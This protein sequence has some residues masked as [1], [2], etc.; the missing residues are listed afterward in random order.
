MVVLY[1]FVFS[2]PVT[3]TPKPFTLLVS[4]EDG[5][6]GMPSWYSVISCQEYT[7]SLT[8]SLSLHPVSPDDYGSVIGQLIQFNTGDTNQTHTIIIN[9]DDICED[10]ANEFFLSNI[11]LDSGA[12]PIEVIRPQAT[13][14]IDVTF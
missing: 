6:A 12:P 5:T 13:V 14:I 9:P 7:H 3:G 10:N 1:I 2:H 4:T 8:L 11:D